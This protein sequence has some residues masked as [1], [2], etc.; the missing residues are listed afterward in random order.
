[1][2]LKEVIRTEGLDNKTFFEIER[3]SAPMTEERQD[4]SDEEFSSFNPSAE[5]LMCGEAHSL[6]G[7]NV[8]LD[9]SKQGKSKKYY[10]NAR[11]SE[12]SIR[13]WEGINSHYKQFNSP[14]VGVVQWN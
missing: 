13:N 8:V 3:F 10:A 6:K 1:M 2:Y 4:E 12:T 11:N 14:P 5:K 7:C 9:S